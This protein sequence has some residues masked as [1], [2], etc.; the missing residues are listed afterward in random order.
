MGI[1]HLQS[2]VQDYLGKEEYASQILLTEQKIAKLLF[3]FNR[4]D[5]SVTFDIL[6]LRS[7]SNEYRKHN[8]RIFFAYKWRS[9]GR[10]SLLAESD[11]GV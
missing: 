2:D 8:K 3:T 1:D 9:L 11:H 5:Y 7:V 6:I 4:E 10:Y